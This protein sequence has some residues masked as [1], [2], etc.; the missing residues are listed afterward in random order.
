VPATGS[1]PVA[2]YHLSESTLSHTGTFNGNLRLQ[3]IVAGRPL[4]LLVEV[5]FKLKAQALHASPELLS[6]WAT[7][8]ARPALPVSQAMC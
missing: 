6:Y 7:F 4:V 8:S 3:V 2:W 1:E 5:P